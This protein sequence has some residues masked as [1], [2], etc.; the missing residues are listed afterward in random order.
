MPKTISKQLHVGSHA[1]EVVT[2]SHL[3]CM[4]TPKDS[5]DFIAKRHRAKLMGGITSPVKRQLEKYRKHRRLH[6]RSL[7]LPKTVV[8]SR[9]IADSFAQSEESVTREESDTGGN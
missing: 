4:G 2:K 1:K 8:V 6:R 7:D 9:R 3:K 5:M